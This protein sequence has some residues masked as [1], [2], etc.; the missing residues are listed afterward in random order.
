MHFRLQP[1][2][3]VPQIPEFKPIK[4]EVGCSLLLVDNGEFII[5]AT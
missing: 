1:T 4:N 5:I 2:A 3:N